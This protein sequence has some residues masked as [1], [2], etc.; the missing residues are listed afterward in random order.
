MIRRDSGNEV[1]QMA[2]RPGRPAKKKSATKKVARKAKQ[3]PPINS[4]PLDSLLGYHLRL[5][6]MELRRSF[7]EHVA[8]GDVRPGLASLLQLVVANPG[9]SQVE[10]SRVMHINKA[11]LVA[12]LD[13]AE[14]SG[15]LKRVRSK[16]DRRRHELAILPAGEK[17]AATLRKQALQQEMKYVDRFSTDE[18]EL[19]V[20][21]LQR[22]YD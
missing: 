17:M 20:D 3:R 11:T 12:L 1:N 14:A 21:F 8:D 15:W 18:L 7:L 22:I 10:L 19:M 6:M 13:K 4:E 9:A 2:Q 5:A 16:E